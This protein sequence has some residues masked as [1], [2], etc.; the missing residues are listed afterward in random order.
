MSFS[1]EDFGFMARALR[2]AERGLYTTTPNPRVGCVIARDGRVLGEGWHEK[3]GGAHAE[4]AALKAAGADAAGATVYVSLEPC[5]HHG[6]TPPCVDALVAAKVARVVA[7]MQDPN[8][9]VAGKGLELLRDA[10]IAAE[11]GLMEEQARELNLGFVS[12]MTRG[13]PWMRVKIAASLDGKTALANGVSQWIGGPDARRDGHHWRAR[14]CAVMTGIGTLKDDDPRLTV[15]DVQ[16]TRQPL[17]IVV[18]SRLRITPQAKLLDGGAVLVATATRDDA[19]AAALK[20]KGADVVVLPNDEGKVD[21]RKLTNHLG[22]LGLNEVLVEAGINLDSALLRAGVVDELLL[23]LA[24]HL[25][26]DAGRGMLDLGD[27]QRMDQ[28]L[29]LDIRDTRLFGPDLRVLAR[30]GAH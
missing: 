2:L 15:R 21:L 5:A 11:S 24:P 12:R 9:K 19:K 22:G 25:L 30:L 23:Y 4:V 8:P 6:R 29:E 17:R 20:A 3:A 14:S 7:A 18:D 1:V 13:R 28:R 10:G 16:T 26:G 27:L